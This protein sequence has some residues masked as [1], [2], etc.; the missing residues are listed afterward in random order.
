MLRREFFTFPGFNAKAKIMPGGMK[1]AGTLP[2]QRSGGERIDVMRCG[3]IQDIALY[4]SKRLLSQID[5]HA[6]A[7]LLRDLLQE[8][9]FLLRGML[10][11]P[12]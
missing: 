10:W 11:K 7:K 1:D 4:V 9:G 5:M 3:H 8:F 6:S 12:A 2:H